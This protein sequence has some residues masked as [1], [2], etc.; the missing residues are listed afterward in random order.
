L[1]FA[2]VNA[3]SK[4]LAMPMQKIRVVVLKRKGRFVEDMK[5]MQRGIR[6]RTSR[7]DFGGDRI[8]GS[9]FAHRSTLSR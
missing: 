4:K 9:R 1:S 8:S 6:E 3:S 5:R 2:F 7:R